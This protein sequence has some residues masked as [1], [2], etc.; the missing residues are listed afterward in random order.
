MSRIR[1]A[2][3]NHSTDDV[4]LVTTAETVIISSGPA[5]TP[6]QTHRVIIKAWAQLTTGTGTTAVTPRI[7]R[8]TAVGGALVGEANAEEVKAVAE[9]TEPLFI[10]VS[11]ERASEE[12]VEYSLT[13]EQAGASANGSVLQSAI[14]VLVL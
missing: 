7:R 13:L 9:S 6:F 4:T 14:E 1:D 3:I 12:S 10:M 5:K 11:E 8:G 2:I